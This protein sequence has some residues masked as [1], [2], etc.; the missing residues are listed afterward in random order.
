MDDEARA[1]QMLSETE[2]LKRKRDLLAKENERLRQ[3][4]RARHVE[5]A[6]A[7]EQLKTE[8]EM[9]IEQ[10][11]QLGDAVETSHL[12]TLKAFRSEIEAI[13]CWNAK[14]RD[15]YFSR[16]AER[17]LFVNNNVDHDERDLIEEEHLYCE[18]H[19]GDIQEIHYCDAHQDINDIQDIDDVQ[20]NGNNRSDKAK[21]SKA[22]RINNKK[23]TKINKKETK[24]T[25]QSIKTNPSDQYSVV[26]RS[27]S[28]LTQSTVSSSTGKKKKVNEMKKINKKKKNN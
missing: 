7:C 26:T 23:E 12:E 28:K 19:N 11:E 10:F 13:Q 15:K 22:K 20:D 3:Y 17:I 2:K 4:L 18:R 9:Q 21:K 16:N 5:S 14:I 1:H 27:K 24:R 6:S 8:I 25:K